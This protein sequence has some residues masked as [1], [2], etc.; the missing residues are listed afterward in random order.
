M[1]KELEEIQE[2]IFV[3]QGTVHVGFEINRKEKFVVQFANKVVIGAYNCA[4]NK[5]TIFIYK[6]VSD[7]SGYMLRKEIWQDLMNDYGE[8]SDYFK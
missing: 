2:V 1:F 6:A 3:Q 8:I 7:V 4:V 5:K